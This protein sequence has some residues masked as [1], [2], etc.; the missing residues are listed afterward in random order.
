MRASRSR[1][2]GLGLA[3]LAAFAGAATAGVP[4]APVA[5]P[6]A[7]ADP[8]VVSAPPFELRSGF[9]INLHHAL[10][11]RSLSAEKGA[12]KGAAPAAS[13]PLATALGPAERAAWEQALAYY[14]AEIGPHDVFER[15]MQ[16]VDYTLA[17]LAGDASP[18]GAPL[19]PELAAALERAAP[20]YRQHGWP[21]QARANRFWIAVAAPMVR[22]LGP[23]MMERLAAAYRVPWP[24]RPI[25]VDVVSY[26]NWAGGYTT[27]GDPNHTVIT[28]VEPGY[29]GFAA[30]EMLFHE[31][32]H[33]LLDGRNDPVTRAVEREARAQK[34]AAPS[35]LTHALIFYTAGEVARR[36]LAEAGVRDYVPVADRGLWKRAWPTLKEPLD[37]FWLPYL[38]GKLAFDPAIA[39]I[40]GSLPAS[41][42]KPP[43][44]AAAPKF[45][46]PAPTAAPR[47]PS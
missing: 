2:A 44:P 24:G 32:S 31:A 19:K 41:A 9:W 16:H 5:T 13:D 35:N 4:A 38:E 17:D 33:T 11:G 7:G 22:E 1:L 25:L 40:V 28:S 42:A 6:A 12:E 15:A 37:R 39:G 3:V 36:T 34:R 8:A 10:Y 18:R 27:L 30:L 29:Q 21:D 46:E 26:A 14:R 43:G 20:V 47:P 45:P 23:R